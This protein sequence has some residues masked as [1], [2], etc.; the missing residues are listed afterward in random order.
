MMWLSWLIFV[1]SL[2]LQVLVLNSLRRGAYKDY[3]LVF[4]YSLV[5]FFTTIADGAMWAKLIPL[6]MA[7][8]NVYFYRNEA[9]RQFM[10]FAVVISLIDHAIGPAAYRAR[11]RVLLAAVG[12]AS[13]LISLQIH[14]SS[15]Q[16]FVYWMTQVSRDLSFESVGLTLLLWLTLISSGK[17]DHQLLMVTGGLGLQFTGEA[18][19]QSFRQLSQNHSSALILGNIVAGGTHAL[20]LYVWHAA[21][22]KGRIK[23][24]EPA[25]ISPGA[26]PRPAPI[27]TSGRS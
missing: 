21:F 2:A 4:A 23:E 17:K 6:P 9:V 8:R 11:V 14:S 22:K 18:I 12:V 15:S 1:V 26:S 24:K 20:R 19:G 5:L 25:G 3:S 27:Q 10:L 13:V 16:R 7:V